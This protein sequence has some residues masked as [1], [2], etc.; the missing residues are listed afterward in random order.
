MAEKRTGL[1]DLVQA[2]TIVSAI[3]TIHDIVNRGKTIA[4]AMARHDATKER[5]E[6]IETAI[7]RVDAKLSGK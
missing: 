6:T 3:V 5:L 7:K 4:D 1:G 2:F